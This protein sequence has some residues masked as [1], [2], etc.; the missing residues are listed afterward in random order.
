MRKTISL[1]IIGILLLALATGAQAVAIDKDR[2]GTPITLPESTERI[3]C[4]GPSN[5]E[6]ISALGLAD[7]LVAVDDYSANVEGLPAGLPM[8]DMLVPD[9]ERIL[10]LGPDVLFVPG[11]SKVGGEDPYKPVKEAGV[12]VIYMP[13][14]NS[15][16]GIKEDIRYIAAVLGRAEKGEEIVG[17][18]EAE[19][20]AI[21]AIG[22]AVTEKKSVYFEIAAAPYM[23]SF[24]DGVFLHEMIE[25]TGALN[26]LADQ[27]SWISITDEA[28][29][30]LNPD[31]IL[32]S[33]NYIDNPIEELKNRP[34]WDALDA[35]KDGRVF[36]IDTDT[37]SRPSQNIVKALWEIALAVYPD[38]YQE[39]A[40]NQQ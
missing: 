17:K 29:L 7:R 34:S 11:L 3:A 1:G 16:A 39:A 33:V 21:K 35:V 4:F 36:A 19:I 10:D 9:A 26:I 22:D 31:V 14:S 32:T 20:A 12:C 37:S 24:G 23:C 28:V 13:S 6:I 40:R 25:L 38:L 2:E 30:A 27:S 18:M 8:F 15:V 5:T